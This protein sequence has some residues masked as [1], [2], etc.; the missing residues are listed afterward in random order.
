L[1]IRKNILGK[2]ELK[3]SQDLF[4]SYMILTET[5]KNHKW[6]IFLAV[7]AGIIVASPQAYFRYDNQ[8]LYQGQEIEILRYSPWTPLV[9]EASDGHFGLGSPFFKDGKDD[10]YLHQ[11]VDTTTLAV[12]GKIFLLDLNNILLFARFLFPFL[13]FLA[14]YGFVILFSKDKLA[15]L[16]SSSAVILGSTL[17]GRQELLQLLKGESPVDAFPFFQI[18]VPSQPLLF[19]FSFL[20]VFWL[21]IEKK[22]YRYGIIS[23]AILGLT[24]YEYFY[25]WTFLYA[26][27]GVL[28][29]IYLFQKKWLDLKR[30]A[31]VL[32]GGLLIAIPYFLNLY[33]AS[34]YPTYPDLEQRFG[35]IETHAP[36]L[37][38][39]APLLLIVFLLFFPR[40]Y[41]ERYFFGLA[42]AI[43]PLIV[44]NQQLITGRI[45]EPGHY[46]WR[47]NVPLAI[48]FLLVIFFAWFLAKKGKWAVIKK[49]LATFIIGISLYTA[50]FI[51]T[52]FYAD[53]E[54]EA[55]QQQRYGPL[56]EW[57]NQNA[58]KEEVVFA[59]GDLSYLVTIYTPLN[60][61]YHPL[62]RYFLSAS[63][64][65]LLNDIFLY[66]RLDRVNKE[67]A[68][69]VFFQ[70]RVK[71][72]AVIYG[73]YYQV[74]TGS[75]QNIP[76]EI[77]EEFV[78]RYQASLSI[79]TDVFLDKL[80]D[81][82]EVKYLVWDTKTEPQW[83]LD[84]YPFLKKTAEIGDFIIYQRN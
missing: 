30:I 82:Y 44:L 41:K 4:K 51:Q 64:D 27:A 16:A 32:L 11:P 55:I 45:M 72:S 6:A 53:R 12:L 75:Y 68:E 46:H 65:R 50:I 9:R 10:P 66:Y 54:N 76:D 39:V 59:D 19:F 74:L 47:Y 70:D 42:L 34:L 40:K 79:P 17:F 37:G 83:Q 63:R 73:M 71:F 62:A 57:L 14:I 1:K 23:T 21:F 26:F 24:F 13:L 29:L 28:G 69:E 49:M 2:R 58:E 15:A 3:E 25:N 36:L 78:Q 60:V 38:F 20:L 43:T 18:V 52:A 35:I 80:W 84:Q 5:I 22:Q 81:T 31:L 33:R 8:D 67:E 48:I 77:I 61:F 56:I 7:L